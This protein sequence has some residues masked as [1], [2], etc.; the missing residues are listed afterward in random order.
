VQCVQQ[1]SVISVRDMADV[2]RKE[3]A[4]CIY[5]YLSFRSVEHAGLRD[6]LQTFANLGAKY[7]KFDVNEVLFG[8]NAV[9]RETMRMSTELKARFKEV[10]TSPVRT[11]RSL[12]VWICTLTI[13]E[14]KPT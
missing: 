8:R 6:L 1:K 5:G 2:K 14:R 9:T 12:S 7:G 11:T 10:L 4:Y 13:T 3:V